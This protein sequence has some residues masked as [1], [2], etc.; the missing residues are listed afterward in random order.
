VNKKSYSHSFS[1]VKTLKIAFISLFLKSYSHNVKKLFTC[2]LIFHINLVNLTNFTKKLIKILL[3]KKVIHILFTSY[4]HS[5]SHPNNRYYL[6]L[7]HFFT[8]SHPLLLLLT[9][10]KYKEKKCI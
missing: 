10:F 4:S 8:F 3:S 7:E 9:K 1:H 2:E 5:F 6:Y